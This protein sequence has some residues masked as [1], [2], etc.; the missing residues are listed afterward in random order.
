[1][2]FFLLEE[3]MGQGQSSQSATNK[4]RD[5]DY[6]LFRSTVAQQKATLGAD[7][8]RV[9][10][11]YD[12]GPR[13]ATP[14]ICLHSTAGTAEC[15]Y[16]Q[17]NELVGRGVRLIAVQFPAYHTHDEW[18]QGFDELLDLLHIEK[19]HI[20]GA[21]LGGF[22]A[23]LYSRFHGHRIHSLILVNTYCDNATMRCPLPQFDYSA[24][25]LLKRS[26]LKN[27]AHGDLESRIADS[28]DFMVDQLDSLT[29][30]DVAARM[31]LNCGE[32]YVGTPQV[33]EENITYIETLDFS[34]VPET[35][36]QQM[37]DKYPKAK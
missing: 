14:L 1:V 22:L 6:S 21:S 31:K 2:G 30:E 16:K 10:K 12:F 7:A 8:E 24:G 34:A 9:W 25:F 35:L 17:F 32:A 33:P 18:I 28:V 3:F 26:I 37:R 13:D 27:F 15:W 5:P 36:R 11:Y 19:C 29:R 4:P 23:Q 20:L